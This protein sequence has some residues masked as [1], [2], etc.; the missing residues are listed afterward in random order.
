MEITHRIHV[1]ANLRGGGVGGQ[2]LSEPIEGWVGSRAGLDTLE[3]TGRLTEIGR[4]CGMEIN[5]EKTKVMRISRHPSPI[6]I[7]IDKK[8]GK[9]GIFKSLG[10]LCKMYTLNYIQDCHG[11]SSIRLKTLFTSKLD[12]N[13]R[14]KFVKGY[15]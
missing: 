10:T 2:S 1:P 4:R 3:K 13:L 14:K 15:I 11:K 7:T 5:V 12:L 9:C 8:T 6:Q